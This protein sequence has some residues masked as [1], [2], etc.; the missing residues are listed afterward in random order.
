MKLSKILTQ[1]TFKAKK[2]SNK[3]FKCLLIVQKVFGKNIQKLLIS[4]NTPKCGGMKVVI[5]AW[6][7]INVP[8]GWK[9]GNLSKI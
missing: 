9:I 2:V 6:R 3:L 1:M 8:K 5:E 7:S 4:L